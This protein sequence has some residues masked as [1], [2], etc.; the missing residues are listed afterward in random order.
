VHLLTFIGLCTEYAGPYGAI[1][2]GDRSHASR[3]S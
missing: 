3:G 2:S 1:R